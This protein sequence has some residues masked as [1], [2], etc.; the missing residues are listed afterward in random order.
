M[1]LDIVSQDIAIKDYPTISERTESS[2]LEEKDV[3]LEWKFL[4]AYLLYRHL[5]RTV[6]EIDLST[7]YPHFRP[8]AGVTF[9]EEFYEEPI[10]EEMLEYDIV[11]KMPPKE[12]HTI[13][14]EIKSIKKAEPKVIKPELL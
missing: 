3:V 12:K 10:P 4:A 11:V 6:F 9:V 13:E 2:K 7:V 8:K 5:L 14:L 1:K